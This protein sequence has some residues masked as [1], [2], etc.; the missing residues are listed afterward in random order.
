[1]G[2]VKTV[3]VLKTK[4]EAF[5][6]EN[7]I[8]LDQALY[9][10]WKL[11]NYEPLYIKYGQTKVECD[12]STFNN[13]KGNILQLPEKV[14]QQLLLPVYPEKKQIT[15]NPLERTI[16]LGPVIAV[17]TQITPSRKELCGHLTPFC[18]ELAIYSA[19]RGAD[20][21]VTNLD[22]AN[23]N[24]D[25]IGYRFIDDQWVKQ[26]VP[27]PNV[28]H[29]R[30]NTRKME[31]SSKWN[32]L[33][34]Y[35]HNNNVPFFNDHF[36]NKWEVHQTIV[37][38]NEIAPYLP[39]T[40]LYETSSQLEWMLIKHEYIFV[41]PIHGNQGK[42]I[43]RIKKTNDGYDLDFT[44]FNG[45]QRMEFPSFHRLSETL[46]KRIHKNYYIV[47]QGLEL[48]T[49]DNRALDFRL[50]CNRNNQG[51][52]KIA[53]AFARVSGKEQ[54]VSNIAQGGKLLNLDQVLTPFFDDRKA[55]GLKHFLVELALETVEILSKE[56]EGIYGE[57]G[58]DLAIDQQ[59]H[60]WLI[61][62]NTKP[63]KDLDQERKNLS[64]RPSA[65]GIIDYASYLANL[66]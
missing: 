22:H 52:W 54:F 42:R 55:L 29:N 38:C 27:F 45:N 12:F 33:K 3:I 6:T 4:N 49:Y 37:D 5:D 18:E 34:T 50:L 36:L 2:T 1:M 19:Q 64:V 62:V 46:T 31:Y 57:L 40:I 43:Y 11:H 39:E 35:C 24:A 7:T 65:R 23:N 13:E 25:I 53:S 48:M 60:P 26:H 59:G 41:K 30:L 32:Q 63:S 28:I 16:H 56:I 15:F 21:F 58:V 44:T 47:Q 9:D 10:T 66:K 8:L 17:L 61:E 20:F 14:S 51:V